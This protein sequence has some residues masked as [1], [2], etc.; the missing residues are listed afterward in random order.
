[1]KKELLKKIG[2]VCPMQTTLIFEKESS[3]F[4]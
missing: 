1:M 2:K 3:A 4:F